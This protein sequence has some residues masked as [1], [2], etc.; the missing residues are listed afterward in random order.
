MTYLLREQ[1]DLVEDDQ[2]LVGEDLA[3]DDAL[4]GLRLDTLGDVDDEQHHV[5]DLGAAHD[6]SD[7]GGVTGAVD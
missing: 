4:S 1:V 6:R 5:D 3:D 2:E 7:Q